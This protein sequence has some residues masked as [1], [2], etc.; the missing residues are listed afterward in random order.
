[1]D[2]DVA[3][4]L[5]DVAAAHLARSEGSACFDPLHDH[6]WRERG[7]Y[8]RRAVGFVQWW[9]DAHPVTG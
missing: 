5:V 6:H 3:A 9:A 4:E 8:R 7:E 1:M 2:E